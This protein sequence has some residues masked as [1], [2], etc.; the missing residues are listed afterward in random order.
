MCTNRGWKETS[1]PTAR[2]VSKNNQKK[3]TL[4]HFLMMLN[5]LQDVGSNDRYLHDN[6]RQVHIGLTFQKLEDLLVTLFR[7]VWQHGNSSDDVVTL[8]LKVY[9]EYLQPLFWCNFESPVTEN[10]F[11]VTHHLQQPFSPKDNNFI[12]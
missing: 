7:L 6:R 11:R 3:W 9:T 10:D 5:L 8:V 12:L 4:K 1:S 2:A